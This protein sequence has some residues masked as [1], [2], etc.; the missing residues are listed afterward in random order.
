MSKKKIIIVGGG[1]GG[2]KSALKLSE[3]DNVSVTLISDK[4]CFWYFPTMY[5]TATGSSEDLSSIPLEVLFQDKIVKLIINPVVEIDKH[6]RSI[7][8]QNGQNLFYDYI[9]FSLGVV[10]NYFG[11][12][13]LAEHSFGV[14]SITD[15][16]RL[17]THLHE[18]MI[19]QA[20]TEL[21]YVIVG[22]GPT[23]I[24]T[25]GQLGTFLSH[26]QERHQL[27][28]KKISVDLVEASKCLLPRMQKS[29][30]KTI[31]KRLRKLGV[32]LILSA[33]VEGGSADELQLNNKAINTKTIIWTAGSSN[34][35]FF[36]QNKFILND[37]GKVNVNQYLE[38]YDDVYVIGDNADT[39]YSGLA[40]TALN[41]A[42]FVAEDIK[43]K[44]SRS[45]RRRYKAKKPISIIPVGEK[46]AF[47]EWGKFKFYGTTGWLLREAADLIGFLDITEPLRASD[48]WLKNLD[49]ESNCSICD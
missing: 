6:D 12:E 37:R 47:V 34:S 46:W 9:V 38:A 48:Q 45:K 33:T 21:H 29:V 24:E 43:N 30:G 44:I 2:V 16:N 22:G 27:P 5:K 7:T 20:S 31:S 13:G 41:D 11:I 1:F 40:Q 39:K 25:A 17:K 26:I 32:N 19:S 18:Q 10:T 23:G 14:K 3:L 36:K 35:P 49:Q 15:A 4:D 42:I 28:K 8:L